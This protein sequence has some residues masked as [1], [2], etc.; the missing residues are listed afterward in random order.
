MIPLKD[1]NPTR[2]FPFVNI[3]L[4]IANVVV[5]VY[6][7][8]LPP[9]AYKMFVLANATIPARVPLFLA[10]HTSAHVALYPLFTSMFL[11][12]GLMHLLGNMLF[13]YIFGDNVEDVFGHFGYL[14]FY[15]VCG[16]GSGL[17]HVAFNFHSAIPALGASGAISGVMGAYAVYFPRHRILTFFFIF[18]IPIPAI[19]ILGYWFVLQFL[20]GINGLGMAQQGGVAFWA[21]VGGFVMGVLIAFLVKR[22]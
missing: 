13:L 3:A 2:T 4:I 10:G 17:L 12:G 14:L 16:I 15:I 20:E 8:T 7:A 21:H 9:Q 1:I 22:R 6:Q 11:H 19:F 5:F 18:L